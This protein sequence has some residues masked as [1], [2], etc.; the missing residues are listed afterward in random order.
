MHEVQLILFRLTLTSNSKQFIFGLMNAINRT[1]INGNLFYTILKILEVKNKIKKNKSLKYNICYG[2]KKELIGK[3]SLESK[4]L[5]R[6]SMQRKETM[7]LKAQ[8][9]KREFYIKQY[10]DSLPLI[11]GVNINN[12]G[13]KSLPNLVKQF[14][15]LKTLNIK[16]MNK[17]NKKCIT[18]SIHRGAIFE[19]DCNRRIQLND[20]KCK[21]AKYIYID[22]NK[23]E[24]QFKQYN[25]IKN[26]EKDNI[27]SGKDIYEISNVI[28][29]SNINNIQ[30]D[31]SIVIYGPKIN[32]KLGIEYKYYNNSLNFVDPELLKI[33]TPTI[34]IYNSKEGVNVL[35]LQIFQLE[36]DINSVRIP[37]IKYSLQYQNNNLL[38]GYYINIS[39]LYQIN[40]NFKNPKICY[41]NMSITEFNNEYYI[42]LDLFTNNKFIINF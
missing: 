14:R 33:K 29:N 21:N 12:G 41:D 34:N 13:I 20:G 24:I 30:E 25:D 11:A 7:R 28:L 9:I 1:L 2:I 32:N 3:L 15:I 6:L 10:N 38:L 16:K 22:K 39:N 31:N 18:F 37:E 35:R 23:P 27:L 19:N 42:P 40:S 17:N 5:K 26:V 8:P 36:Y 4:Y